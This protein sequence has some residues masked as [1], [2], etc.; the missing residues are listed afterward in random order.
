MRKALQAKAEAKFHGLLNEA[1]AG[2]WKAEKLL[3]EKNIELEK[4][5]VKVENLKE[6][7]DRALAEVEELKKEIEK[8]CGRHRRGDPIF[9]RED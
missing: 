7:R 6:E 8:M 5:K 1:K 3:E 9:D 2:K 4:E